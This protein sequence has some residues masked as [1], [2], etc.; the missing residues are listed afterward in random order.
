MS[1]SSSAAQNILLT[2]T[3]AARAARQASTDDV[4]SPKM[5]PRAAPSQPET[6]LLP[7]RRPSGGNREAIRRHSRGDRGRS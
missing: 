6:H 1:T 3:V 5:P 7:A 4:Y 2:G